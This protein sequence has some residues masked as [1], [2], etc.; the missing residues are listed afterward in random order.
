[1]MLVAAL[2]LTWPEP[3][4]VRVWPPLFNAAVTPRSLEVLFVQV[5]G[6]PSV[7]G[8]MMETVLDPEFFEMPPLRVRVCPA[9]PSV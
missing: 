3:P 9:V 7:T 8:L 4:K 2:K 1:M 5:C 6:A